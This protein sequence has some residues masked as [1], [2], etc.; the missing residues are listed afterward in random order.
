MTARAEALVE[1]GTCELVVVGEGTSEQVLQEEQGISEQVLPEEV[2]TSEQ[3][4]MEEVEESLLVLDLVVLVAVVA[5]AVH[6]GTSA[7]E[8]RLEGS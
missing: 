3:V 4:L 5:V 1:T 7:S 8:G 6:S 2:G